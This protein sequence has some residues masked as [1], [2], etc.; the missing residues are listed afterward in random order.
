MNRRHFLESLVA[1]SACTLLGG[2]AAR[3]QAAGGAGRYRVGII[4]HTGRGGFGHG[5]DSM[6]AHVASTEVVGWADGGAGPQAVA[7]ASAKFPGAQCFT[8]YGQMLA[9]VRP[10]IVAV[11]PRHVEQ[12]SAIVLAAAAAGVR[13]VYME[14]PFVRDL[15]EADGIVALCRERGLRVALAHRNRYHPV[16]PVVV[17]LLRSGR[18]GRLLEVRARGKEDQRGGALDL[19]VLGSHVLNLATVFAGQPVA[20]TGLLYQDGRPVARG[21]VRAGDEGLGLLGG[22]AVHAR[23]EME[24]GVPLYF[25][26]VRNAGVKAAGFGLQLICSEAVVDLR[27][28]VEPLVHVRWGNPFR[29]VPAAGGWEPVTSGGVGQPEPLG[30]MRRLVGGHVL[31]AEDL[32]A[33][34]EEKREPLCGAEAGRTTVEMIM[35][36][37]ESHRRGG[38]RVGLPLAERVNPL[39]QL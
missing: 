6:W 20:C 33:A 8:E 24:A 11:C 7:A 25:D 16:L 5:L 14:K 17:E 35:A 32:L 10:D 19:W 13:G 4:G 15:V 39:G 3:G 9:E 18:F 21:D 31:P 34:V 12:H 30:D 23:F 22:N 1:T 37:F 38:E 29:P 27:V 36:V 2:A 26:S 28:D